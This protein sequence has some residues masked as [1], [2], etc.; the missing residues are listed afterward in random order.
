MN[1]AASLAADG[2]ARQ[3]AGAVGRVA[4]GRLTLQPFGRHGAWRQVALVVDRQVALDIDRRVALVVK[5]QRVVVGEVGDA[6]AHR[7]PG[8]HEQG[9]DW[10]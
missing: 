8:V 6:E 1:S 10:T 4:W 9:H 7:D 5:Q 2:A 3:A